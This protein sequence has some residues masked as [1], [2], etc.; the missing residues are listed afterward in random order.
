MR[1]DRESHHQEPALFHRV[2]NQCDENMSTAGLKT[3]LRCNSCSHFFLEQEQ[4]NVHNSLCLQPQTRGKH[5]S[6]NAFVI[7]I[8]Y[9]GFTTVLT[10]PEDNGTYLCPYPSCIQ[11]TESEVF[12]RHL[13]VHQSD[14]L[15][16]PP[17]IHIGSDM[18]LLNPE[19]EL[20]VSSGHLST[21]GQGS[22]PTEPSRIR[23]SAG[24][25]QT[26]IEIVESSRKV[27]WPCQ[28]SVCNYIGSSRQDIRNHQRQHVVG[29]AHIEEWVACKGCSINFAEGKIFED[30]LAV[31]LGVADD[32]ETEQSGD[33]T[34][35]ER[36]ASDRIPIN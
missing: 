16:L 18:T 35:G 1:L 12:A 5:L 22:K 23:T 15:L 6:S 36:S 28:H 20:S 25:A 2:M 4:Y 29:S 31:C 32:S 8:R 24:R 3:M 7:L 14:P 19:N 9:T 17:S 27:F 10:G 33:E 26:K 21:S 30:H 13:Q 11:M 34:Q